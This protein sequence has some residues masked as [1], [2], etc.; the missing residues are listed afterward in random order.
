MTDNRIA[1]AIENGNLVVPQERRLAALVVQ[2]H[3]VVGAVLLVVDHRF[4]TAFT[5]GLDDFRGLGPGASTG[6]RAETIS[7]ASPAA[8]QLPR[9]AVSDEHPCTIGMVGWFLRPNCT[10]AKD[11]D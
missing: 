4:G 1:L 8:R 10:C 5:E 2:Q 7:R 3:H 6:S 11:Y 9:L